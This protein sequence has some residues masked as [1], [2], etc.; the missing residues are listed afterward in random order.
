MAAKDYWREISAALV[1][2]G[3]GI[4]LLY[5]LFVASSGSPVA[6]PASVAAHLMP[7]IPLAEARSP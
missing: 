3:L 2:K 7:T 4:A 5:C 6:T 1:L